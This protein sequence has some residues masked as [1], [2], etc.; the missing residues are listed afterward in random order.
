M[1]VALVA[2]K[3]QLQRMIYVLIQMSNYHRIHCVEQGFEVHIENMQIA[4]LPLVIML[5]T[6]F[7]VSKKNGGKTENFQKF[8]L[9]KTI[10]ASIFT[11]RYSL[12]HEHSFCAF[13]SLSCRTVDRID[14]RNPAP[15]GMYKPCK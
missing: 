4:E 6:V 13:S 1:Y 14:G 9:Q 3:T 15:A 12:T 8:T 11:L 7:F 10:K 2:Q 5:T